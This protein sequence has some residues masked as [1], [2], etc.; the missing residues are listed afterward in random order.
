ME[1][2]FVGYGKNPPVVRWPNGARLA[3][4]FVINYEEGSEYSLLDGDSSHETNNEV[5][6]PIPL[7]QRDLNNESMFEYGSRVGV[8]RLFRLF[9]RYDAPLTIYACALAVERNPQVAEEIRRREYE[10]VGHGYRWEEAFRMDREQEQEAMRKA[11]ESLRRTTGQRPLGWFVRYGPSVNTRELVVEEGGFLYDS[12]ALDDD[13][14]YYVT[15]QGRPWLVVP[16]SMEVNDARFWRGGGLSTA[17]DFYRCMK[18]AFDCLYEEGA[19]HPK[20]MT[21][22]LHCRIAGRPSRFPAVQRFMQYVRAFPDV[23]YAR[24]IDIARWWLEHYPPASAGGTGRRLG[25]ED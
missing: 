14:P 7:D 13:L 20:M 19:T 25:Q 4:S 12:N 16:Y 23:W 11:V 10:V 5:P 9:Q 8:W 2:N 17:D 15:V 24:R 18:D 6:S 22:G 21:V 3:L 1:R